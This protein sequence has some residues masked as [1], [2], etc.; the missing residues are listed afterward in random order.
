MVRPAGISFLAGEATQ[1]GRCN[2]VAVDQGL[3]QGGYNGVCGLLSG[4]PSYAVRFGQADDEGGFGDGSHGILPCMLRVSVRKHRQCWRGVQCECLKERHSDS[5]DNPMRAAI[6]RSSLS[7]MARPSDRQRPNCSIS[8]MLSWDSSLPS[9]TT[10]LP[11]HS[12]HA[13]LR[14]AITSPA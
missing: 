4:L 2:V 12:F 8:F 1:S 11:S 7:A 5:P 13:A 14:H 3:C 9:Q 10:S 6:S